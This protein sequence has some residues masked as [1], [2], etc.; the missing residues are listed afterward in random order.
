VRRL[1]VVVGLLVCLPARADDRALATALFDEGVRLAD[2]GN[3]AAACPKFE[4]AKRYLV[5]FPIEYALAQCWEN[6]GRTGD[7]VQEYRAAVATA[8]R[9]GDPRGKLAADRAA[10]L[11][12]V[13]LTIRFPRHWDGIEFGVGLDGATI[14]RALDGVPM[15]VNPGEHEIV[16]SAMSAS[17]PWRQKVMVTTSDVV[18]QI[19]DR[20]PPPPNVGPTPPPPQ[21][22][23]EYRDEN[24]V[25][26]L[27]PPRSPD[28]TLAYVVGASG[29]AVLG[30]GVVIGL[31]ARSHYN[32]ANARY[33][34]GMLTCDDQAG[35]DEV[36]S[37]KRLG[38][39]GTVVG[40]V[41]VA[42]IATGVVLYL[43]APE[44][45]RPTVSLDA[46][47]GFTGLTV[48]GSF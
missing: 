33:C 27:S 46:R 25:I 18:V 43:V 41:G 11:Q 31:V 3:F 16:A 26:H 6:L 36:D 22:P 37:A 47:P 7:A 20:G 13:H 21:P 12:P 39:V 32:D 5:T 10:R 1:A 34:H 35:A 28:H 44:A 45:R 14:D 29:V 40:A 19:P 4:A 42:G 38:N 17:P 23:G 24:G 8:E 9:T 2:S 30:A 48:G 15:I